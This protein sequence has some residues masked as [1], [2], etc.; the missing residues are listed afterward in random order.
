MASPFDAPAFLTRETMSGNG[1]QLP[2]LD[3]PSANEAVWLK[4][5]AALIEREQNLRQ[6]VHALESQEMVQIQIRMNSHAVAWVWRNGLADLQQVEEDARYRALGPQ[7]TGADPPSAMH[8][9]LLPVCRGTMGDGQDP[10]GGGVGIVAPATIG[11]WRQRPRGPGRGRL[12]PS[13]GP[14]DARSPNGRSPSG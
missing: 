13:V 4:S 2:A 9:A 7:G 8:P 14:V 10:P 1:S 11:G 6:R 5:P 3:S 12:L